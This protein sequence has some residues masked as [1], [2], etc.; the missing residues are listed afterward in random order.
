[1][2]R[3]A[4]E[5]YHLLK[6]PLSRLRIN[7]LFARFVI[8]RKVTGKVFADNSLSP[9][10]F[11]VVHP[12]GMSLLF[13]E[14]NNESFNEQLL[15]YCLNKNKERIN[16]EWLQADPRNWDET[17]KQLFD[18]FLVD[19]SDS[20]E[21][22]PQLIELNTRVNFKFNKDKYL[23]F[24]QNNIK[25]K[26]EI[27]RTD[28]ESF[29]NMK[30]SVIPV[31]FWDS[32]DDFSKNGVGFSLFFRDKLATTAYSAFIFD[33]ELELGMETIPEFRGKG[34]AKYACASLI[35]YCV[36]NNYEPIWAC[37]LEN[38]PS[39]FLAQKLGFVPELMLPYYRLAK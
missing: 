2:V 31:H 1:M 6:E 27:A 24:K 12:Y 35:D 14:N 28:K 10:T 7:T 26:Y 25:T 11:Y 29:L 16:Y 18:N 34:F 17:L 23:E 15:N 4:P 22:L 39:Y 5:K 3:L 21:A 13:G 30:G 19:S 36:A 9:R 32:A 20:E 8:E 37:R 33:K 38:K